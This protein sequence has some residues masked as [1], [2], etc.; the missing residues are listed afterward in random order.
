MSADLIDLLQNLG[1]PE[2]LVVGDLMLDRY[3]WGEAERISQEAP[4]ILLHADEREE[5][6][7]GA[8]NVAAMLRVLGAKVS[9]AGVVGMDAN[10][11]RIYRLLDDRS[12]N[13]DCV[14][15]DSQ[16]PTTVKERYMGRSAHKHPQQMLRV[17]YEVRDPLSSSLEQKLWQRL[18]D[19]IG[20]ADIILISDY[21]KGVCTPDL[22]SHLIGLARQ[23]NK[24]SLVD[25]IRC[26]AVGHGSNAPHPYDKYH[27]CSAMTPNR[28]E[29][30]LAAGRPVRNNH[31]ALGAGEFLRRRFDLEA[32]IVTLDKDGM[33]LIH[34]DGRRQLFPTRSRQVYDIA[35]A[36]DMVMSVL[37]LALAAGIDYDQAIRLANIAGGLEVEKTGVVPVTREEILADLH[38][39]P[40]GPSA[41]HELSTIPLR[42]AADKIVSRDALTRELETC[43]Q[44]GRR[45]VFTNGCFD[46]LHA[47]HI[48]CL[49]EARAQGDVLVVG[50][51]SDESVRRLKGPHRPIN[52]ERARAEVLAALATVD[53]VVLF[54]EFTPLE[55]IQSVRPDVLVKAADYAKDQVVGA[56]FVASYGGRLHLAALREGLSTTSLVKKLVA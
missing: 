27:G 37:A 50:L 40:V 52:P 17:D 49:M 35:G 11:G 53:Y 48:A 8:S 23:L 15:A 5:R 20:R 43:R 54:E 28:L 25:P 51:N 38:A 10:A 14:L 21:D 4:V 56:D 33:A 36:G 46:L 31:D 18:K 26:K 12:I 41:R 19:A 3:V 39:T 2:V 9:L 47:G 30:G 13:H 29:A 55:L 24:R 44:A 32:A 6:L 16:R 22:T 34:R 42:S 45:I 1:H 7:G